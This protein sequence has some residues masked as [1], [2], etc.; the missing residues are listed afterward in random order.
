MEKKYIK[1][2][3]PFPDFDF[4]IKVE[5]DREKARAFQKWCFDNNVDWYVNKKTF[6]YLNAYYYTV[7]GKDILYGSEYNDFKK[8]DLPEIKFEDYFIDI[9]PSKNKNSKFPFT[10][11]WKDARKIHSIACDDWRRKLYL[12]WGKYFLEGEGKPIIVDEDFYQ[13]MRK[14]SNSKQNKVLDEIFGSDEEYF[15]VGDVVKVDNRRSKLMIVQ[16]S[17]GVYTLIVI[18][19]SFKQDI[20]R[21]FSEGTYYLPHVYPDKITQK[22]LNEMTCGKNYKFIKIS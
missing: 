6:N 18:D 17:D 14:A 19:C 13:Q 8:S 9:E 2:H 5:G 11:F 16:V 10:L 15:Q 1:D 22:D 12:T 3:K 4:K 7:K 20:G 21:T